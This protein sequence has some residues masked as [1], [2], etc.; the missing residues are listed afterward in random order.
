MVIE[1]LVILGYL[2]DLYDLK[3]S[4]KIFRKIEVVNV[5]K[6]LEKYSKSQI[7]MKW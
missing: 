5:L 6:L 4:V 3:I 1:F 2:T 7:P